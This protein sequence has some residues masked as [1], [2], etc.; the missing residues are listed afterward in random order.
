[1][2]YNRAITKQ[3]L[4]ENT[5]TDMGYGRLLQSEESVESLKALNIGE[6]DDCMSIFGAISIKN[7]RAADFR[8]ARPL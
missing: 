6:R 1:M 2:R 3:E 8:R 7:G 4:H 5:E